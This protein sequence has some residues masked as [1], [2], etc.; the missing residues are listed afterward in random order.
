MVD[1]IVSMNK[2][3]NAEGKASERTMNCLKGVKLEK[4]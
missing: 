2:G 3:I 1:K 4:D